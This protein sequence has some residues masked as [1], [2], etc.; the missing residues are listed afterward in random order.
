MFQGKGRGDGGSSQ[1]Q[2]PGTTKAN[3][4]GLVP[5]INR[6]KWIGITLVPGATLSSW[7]CTL[8]VW[9]LCRQRGSWQGMRYHIPTSALPAPRRPANTS[10]CL[11]LY[12]ILAHLE[13]S[14]LTALRKVSDGTAD[15]Q[16]HCAPSPGKQGWK[17]CCWAA[18]EPVC[19][20]KSHNEQ[21]QQVPRHGEP[22]VPSTGGS[23]EAPTCHLPCQQCPGQLRSEDGASDLCI[24]CLLEPP[25]GKSREQLS[26]TCRSLQEGKGAG[27]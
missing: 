14:W 19:S 22:S 17:L 24:S 12:H 21:S 23:L 27:L 7:I 1:P 4:V 8:A 5:S 18:P 25:C 10:N 20:F 26:T 6:T 11:T 13:L 9:I 3:R 15:S 16:E 2:H